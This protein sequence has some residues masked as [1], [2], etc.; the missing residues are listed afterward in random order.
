MPHK[1]ICPKEWLFVKITT[2]RG[3]MFYRKVR[4]LNLYS[5]GVYI[6][7]SVKSR[8]R[9]EKFDSFSFPLTFSVSIVKESES[10]SYVIIPHEIV[11]F[12]NLKYGDIISYNLGNR[13]FF[14]ELRRGCNSLKLTIPKSAKEANTENKITINDKLK[15]KSPSNQI[16]LHHT[17]DDLYFELK[18]LLPKSTA[19]DNIDFKILEI[20]KNKLIVGVKFKHVRGTNFKYI[21]LPRYVDAKKIALFFGLMH[22]DGSKKFGYYEIYRKYIFSP[23]LNFTNGDPHIIELFLG[24]F[25]ELFKIKRERFSGNVKYPLK[26]D[27][28]QKEKLLDF[29]YR[30]TRMRLQIYKDRNREERWCPAGIVNVS[31]Y[32]ILIAEIIISSLKKFL[33]WIKKEDINYKDIK[34]NFIR[35]IL[36]GDG[37]PVLDNGVLRRLMIAIEFRFEGEIYKEIL[38]SLG[39]KSRNLWPRDINK[40]PQ[41][42]LRKLDIQGNMNFLESLL[43][44]FSFGFSEKGKFYGSLEKQYRFISGALRLTKLRNRKKREIEAKKLKRYLKNYIYD[45]Q[46]FLPI[47]KFYGELI[48]GN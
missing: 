21:V 5:Y 37:S 42:Y 46:S 41:T 1:K 35:G 28:T 7:S 12:L 8:F 4:K 13:L 10:Y 19:R 15:L 2:E 22:S 23:I 38:F 16:T 45:L 26:I 36:M 9:I 3:E 17:K 6:P 18:S 34:K 32:N 39:Y 33:Q 40:L 48:N 31:L 43:E 20:E 30:L 47:P 14:G 24:L 27:E 25:E 11:K 44:N 29:W